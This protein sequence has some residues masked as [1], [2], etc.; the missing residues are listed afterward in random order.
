MPRYPTQPQCP[1][2]ESTSS[3]PILVIRSARPVSDKYQFGKSLFWLGQD[4]NFQLSAQEANASL[5][6]FHHGSQRYIQH[7]ILLPASSG[8][9]AG[10]S[11]GECISHNTIC[12]FAWREFPYHQAF[13]SWQVLELRPS[14]L[15]PPHTCH[16]IT[17]CRSI[18]YRWYRARWPNR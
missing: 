14:P 18:H 5:R 2:M 6:S 4:S 17:S 3:C 8:E 1:N 7:W 15:L 10:S 9:V 11:V 13:T 16:N 12:R